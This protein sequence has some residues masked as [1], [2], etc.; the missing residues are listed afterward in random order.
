M[1]HH[2]LIGRGHREEVGDAERGIGDA[3]ERLAG[4]KIAHDHDGAAGME[5]RVGVAVEPAGVEQRQHHELNRLGRDQRRDAEVHAVPEHHP[6][7]DDRALGM[8]GGARC[9]HHHADVVVRQGGRRRRRAGLGESPL[10]GAV[11][12]VVV[13]F[14]ETGGE[15]GGLGGEGPVVD[16][17]LRA[18]IAQDVFQLGHREPPV[19]RQHDGAQPAA[20]ELQ[21]EVFGAVR[22]EQG[23]AVAA[24]DA[25]RGEGRGQ[26]ADALVERGI[27]DLPAGVQVVDR[28]LPGTPSGVVGDPVVVGNRRH[29]F[30]PRVKPC[31]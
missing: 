18:R 23:D 27:G 11:G 28:E 1:L 31:Q 29:Q 13:D 10:V 7:S 24:G 4:I 25:P 6:V 15:G 16:Q 8:P 9:V 14:E 20:G 21:F 26:S 2:E 17:Q 3:V 22:R 5:H 30:T 19:E 12:A